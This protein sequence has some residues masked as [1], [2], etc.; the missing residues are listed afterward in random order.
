[1][2]VDLNHGSGCVPGRT[3]SAV[4]LLLGAGI[5]RRIDAGL[6]A[7]RAAEPRR[8]RLGA[9]MLAD[10]CARRVAY[11]YR[12]EPAPPLDGRA[13]RIFA[14]G[15]AV[16]DLLAQWIRNAGFDLITIDP[17]TGGQFAFSDGPLEGHAD[18]VIVG[19]PQLGFAYPLLWES[20]GLNDRSWSD[21]VKRGLRLSRPIYYGQVS[22]YMA[23]F[24]L[25]ACLFTALNKNSCE[26]WHDLVGF[27]I[28]EAARLIDRAADIVRG[29]LPSRL[30]EPAGYCSYC[31]FKTPCWGPDGINV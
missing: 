22:L 17:R 26:I 8:A 24:G 6:A 11:Q 25:D 3:T 18:G 5:N 30:D 21:L 14:A 15:H 7:A 10:P 12:G 13:L 23:Y 19:G 9:S 31:E 28:A 1:L 20:K 29:R 2:S 27:D 4:T 16:E